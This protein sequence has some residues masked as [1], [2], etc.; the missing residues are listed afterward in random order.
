MVF[1][2]RLCCLLLSA[3]LL[4]SAARGADE[5]GLWDLWKRHEA[6]SSNHTALV[7]ACRQFAER[8]PSDALLPVARGIEAW[9]LFQLGHVEEGRALL[10]PYLQGTG[11]AVRNGAGEL[12]RGWLT[13]MDIEQVKKSLQAYYREE[14]AYPSAVADVAAHPGIDKTLHPPEA[15]RWGTPW[16]YR[17]VGFRG[18]PGFLDQR[19]EIASAKLGKTSDFLEALGI[20]YG[21]GIRMEPLRLAGSGAGPGALVEFRKTA[22]G[23]GSPTERQV[24][25]LGEGR[26]WKGISLAYIGDNILVTCDRTH[27][28]LFAKPRR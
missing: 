10:L 28:K 18:V 20:P 23:E 5:K 9:H 15:D 1:P 19:Y 16:R 17:L 7:H 22:A 24:F 8:N 21:D 4:S 25:V 11:D 2:S 27:W 26:S 13:R 6:S 12:A 14:V 3:L